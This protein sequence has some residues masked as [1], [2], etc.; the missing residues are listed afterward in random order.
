MELPDREELA[1]FVREHHV[2]YDVEPETAV[3][4]ERREV[5]GFGIRLF[6]T[7]GEAT[8]DVPACPRC[9]ELLSG[10]R[11]FAERLVSSADAASWT[12]VMP[13]PAVLYQSSEV[14]DA[15]EVALTVRV[16]RDPGERRA[17][18][19]SDDRRL[20]ALRDRLEALGVPRRP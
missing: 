5:V 18:G 13:E 20:S 11:A 8:L 12:E 6:A 9:V 14:R 10:L 1:R 15:D 19:A 3:Q 16:Q 2:H 4:G 17:E 7:H